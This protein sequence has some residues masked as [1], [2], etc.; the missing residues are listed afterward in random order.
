[1]KQ[2]FA[3]LAVALMFT[4]PV[5]AQDTDSTTDIPTDSTEMV[6][7]SAM[8]DSA[9]VDSAAAPAE[10]PMAEEAAPAAPAEDTVEA[11]EAPSGYVPND[12]DCDDD[13]ASV[14]PAE[15]EDCD[16]IDD[17]CD[18]IVDEETDCYD[19]DGEK[20]VL[21]AGRGDVVDVRRF[22]RGDTLTYQDGWGRTALVSAAYLGNVEVHEAPGCVLSAL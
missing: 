14:A 16:G 18:G 6:T 1:M 2:L 8:A 9:M 4:A 5:S 13:D 11:C 21:A 15:V 22:V 3:L 7:D 12:T 19:D 17:D 10:A 20:L